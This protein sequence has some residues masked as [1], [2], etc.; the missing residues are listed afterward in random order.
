MRVLEIIL[1]SGIVAAISSVFIAILNRKWSKQDKIREKIDTII[2]DLIA[3]TDA[4]IAAQKVL[5]VD[6]VR[7]VGS[8]YIY[9]KEI[10]LDDKETLHNMHKAYKGLGGNGDLDTIMT[11]VD[12]LPIKPEKVK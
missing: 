9:A 2:A 5:I 1:S 10:D 7:Y 6:R 11:E 4:I 3:K 8:C 12:K